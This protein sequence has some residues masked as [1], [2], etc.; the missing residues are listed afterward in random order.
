MY[1]KIVFDYDKNDEDDKFTDEK[2][3]WDNMLGPK[4]DDHVTDMKRLSDEDLL[5]PNDERKLK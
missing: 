3:I 1:K 4:F 5:F 2:F